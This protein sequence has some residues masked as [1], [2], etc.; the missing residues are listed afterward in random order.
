[1]NIIT[2]LIPF[3]SAFIGWLT[4]HLA[5]SMIFRPHLP[6]NFGIFKI[7]GLLPKRKDEIAKRLAETI[8][9]NLIST[10]DITSA[11]MTEQSLNSIESLL[12]SRMRQFLDE[13][14]VAVNPMLGA[15]INDEL[16]SAIVR[17]FMEYMKDELP[18]LISKMVEG[19]QGGL[20]T[21]E[22]ILEKI[23]KMDL[24]QAE[25]LVRSVAKKEL[26]FIEWFGAFLGFLIGLIQSLILI[27]S[28]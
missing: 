6:L 23:D 27:F 10:E 7:Q 4:N 25:S 13:K 20:N 21:R 22:M 2:I 16:K 28:A 19:A 12:E 8:E 9:S 18:E 3:I 26:G 14:L 11:L 5:I 1:M 15:F 17:M 24:N